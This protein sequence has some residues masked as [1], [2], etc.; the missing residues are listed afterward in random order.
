MFY[1]MSHMKKLANGNVEGI[2]SANYFVYELFVVCKVFKI[3][4]HFLESIENLTGP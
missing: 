4:T 1:L 2:L 3:F